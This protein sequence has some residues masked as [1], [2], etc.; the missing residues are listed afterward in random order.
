M[1]RCLAHMRMIAHARATLAAHTQRFPLHPSPAHTSPVG[2]SLRH[3]C[4]PHICDLPGKAAIHSSYTPNGAAARNQPE[5]GQ[6]RLRTESVGTPSDRKLFLQSCCNFAW[7][8]KKK[9]K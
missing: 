6:H 8:A 9:K 2:S 7:G 1:R 4:A 5:R 3:I